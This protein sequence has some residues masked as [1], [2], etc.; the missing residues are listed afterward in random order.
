MSFWLLVQTDASR[1]QR[2]PTAC[3]FVT[4]HRISSIVF[5]RNRKT[6]LCFWTCE[7]TAD[8]L[9]DYFHLTK[10]SKADVDQ[11][12]WISTPLPVLNDIWL[13]NGNISVSIL[14][15]SWI[16]F[17]QSRGQPCSRSR[18]LWSDSV[19]KIHQFSLECLTVWRVK[20]PNI[21]LTLVDRLN[22]PVG[23]RQFWVN[24]FFWPASWAW[25]SSQVM[26]VTQLELEFCFQ[27]KKLRAFTCKLTKSANGF[28]PE[29]SWSIATQVL[30]PYL[31]AGLGM[32]A[33]GLVM[34]IMQVCVTISTHVFRPMLCFLNV[35]ISF[36]CIIGH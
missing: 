13:F 9:L 23:W 22:K 14:R 33:A 17:Y 24:L 1:L 2:L 26:V 32:V 19:C 36:I 28:L 30:L 34:D 7:N 21:F 15:S 25:V 11:Y 3:P 8:S 18:R 12:L 29:S 6:G 16:T 20:K 5:N 31:V 35:R 27:G 10:M 4:L